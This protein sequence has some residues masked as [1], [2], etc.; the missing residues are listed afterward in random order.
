MATSS[1][2]Q[3]GSLTQLW[4][5]NTAASPDA[6]ARLTVIKSVGDI[7]QDRTEVEVSDL[8]STAVERIGGLADGR[9]ITIEVYANSTTLPLMKTLFDGNV[10][11]DLKIIIPTPAG[12]TYYF[13]LTPLGVNLP[14]T[15]EPNAPLMASLRGRISGS[16]STTPS[17][18]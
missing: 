13:T 8:D 18:A 14:G 1:T 5:W 11:I 12:I 2:A 10:N 15:V 9:E 4:Y 7:G 6:W 3:T 16:I 17:H